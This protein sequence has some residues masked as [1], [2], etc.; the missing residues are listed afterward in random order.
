MSPRQH[1]QRSLS[2]LIN[3]R[4]HIIGLIACLYKVVAHQ[5]GPA[6]CSEKAH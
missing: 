3:V 5:E 4:L 2:V 1:Y 6:A